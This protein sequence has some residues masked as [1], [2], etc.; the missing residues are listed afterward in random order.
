M[1]FP[2]AYQLIRNRL[3]EFTPDGYA[4]TRNFTYGSVSLLS[5]YLSRGVITSKEAYETLLKNN[6]G[7]QCIPFLKQLLW[8]EYFQRKLQHNPKTACNPLYDTTK[9]GMPEALFTASTTIEAVDNG[10]RTLYETGYIHNHLRLYTASICFMAGFSP[11]LPARW[12]YYHLLD[13]D[14]ASNHFSWQWVGGGLTGKRYV[15]NQ[16]NINFFTGTKQTG[17]FLDKSYEHLLAL[18]YV[19]SLSKQAEIEFRTVLPKNSMPKLKG[20]RQVLLYNNYNLDPMWHITGDYER[21]LLLDPSHYKRYPVSDNV[22]NFIL[23]LAKNI[24]GIQI[25]TGSFTELVREYPD[26]RFLAKEHPLFYYPGATV[27]PREWLAPDV[28]GDYPSFSQYFKAVTKK[29]P[30]YAAA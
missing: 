27:E 8:R 14:W 21:V 5:P 18:E 30:E 15:A 13:G 28:T 23:E 12:M 2:T 7:N 22:L 1:L 24:K 16:E 4:G 29:Y 3:S 17:S 10:I 9:A 25:Y 19:E 6:E 11:S 26:T 20:G